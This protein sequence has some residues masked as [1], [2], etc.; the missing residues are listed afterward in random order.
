MADKDET[1]AVKADTAKVT[2]DTNPSDSIPEKQVL[3]FTKKQFVS[4]ST[5][6]GPKRDLFQ[7]ALQDG[8]EYSVEEANAKV[9]DLVERMWL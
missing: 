8:V 1:K 2:A 3:K 5:Y 7:I 4:M 9:N 6:S